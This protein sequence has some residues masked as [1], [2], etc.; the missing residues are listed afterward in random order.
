MENPFTAE[1]TAMLDGDMPEAEIAAALTRLSERGETADDLVA[2]A[3]VLRARMIPVAAPAGAADCCGTG[4]DGRD[5]YNVST[6]VAFVAAACGVPVAKHGNRA[7]TSR[8]GAADVLAHLEVAMD[9]SPERLSAALTAC[10]FAFLLAPRHHPALARVAAARRTLGRRTVFN[11]LGPLINPAR[12]KSQLVGVYD[13]RWL[14]PVA[15]ALRRL[16]SETAWVVH[17][18]DGL[19]EIGLAAPTDAAVL[20]DSKIERRTVGPADFGLPPAPPEALRGGDAAANA[21]ALLD[22]LRGRPSAYRDCVLA[23]AAALLALTGRAAGLPEGV[24]LAAAALDDGRALAVLD[25]YRDF[26]AAP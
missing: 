16:G 23:N 4:G 24:A 8:S 5:T 13:R 26:I 2:A 19:D 1:L 17:S 20:R 12:V 15:E 11:L 10:G 6:A 3:Q 14:E 9:A 22:V 21:A 7:S 18:R 25:R